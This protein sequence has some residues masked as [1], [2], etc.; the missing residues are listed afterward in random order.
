MEVG[1]TE[2]PKLYFE[3][4]D[5]PDIYWPKTLELIEE[6]I[7]GDIDEARYQEVLRHFYL[8][9]GWKLY[10]IQDLIRTLCRLA[11][12]CSSVDGKEKTYDLIKQFLAS[13]EREET[14]YQTEISARKFAEKCVKDGELFVL[15][16]VPSKSEASV[17]WLQREETTFYMDEMKLQQRWQYYISSYIRVE[18]TEGVPRSKLSKVVLT[19]N[20]PSADADPEDGSI[21]KPVSYDENLVVSICLRSSK[22]VWGAGSSESF[23]YSSAPTTKEDKEQHDKATKMSTLARDYR[24]REKF[25]LN[26]SWMKD[27]SQ[28]EVEKHK[29]DYKKWAEGEVEPANAATETRDVEMAD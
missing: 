9:S 16:W 15:C 5:T 4:T 18:P 28:E 17:R 13:R 2:E 24:L 19:R 10:T 22:M 26:N 12:T 7:V 8:A 21:P 20:L 6:F 3:A 29:A 11:L 14:S 23:L 25:V 27:L 1:L